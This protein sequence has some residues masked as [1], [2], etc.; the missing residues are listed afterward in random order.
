ML[1]DGLAAIPVMNFLTKLAIKLVDSPRVLQKVDDLMHGI[2]VDILVCMRSVL[3]RADSRR[4][5]AAAGMAWDQLNQEKFELTLASIHKHRL[6]RSG[7]HED[8][9]MVNILYLMTK[10]D[11]LYSL[12]YFP[13]YLMQVAYGE[14][15]ELTREQDIAAVCCAIIST[16][17]NRGKN[18]AAPRLQISNVV[19]DCGAFVEMCARVEDPLMRLWHFRIITQWSQKPRVLDE[20]SKNERAL[21]YV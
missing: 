10:Q 7:V 6:K 21:R 5:S 9:D 13:D 19:T 16:Q 3:Q 17:A 8:K 1:E 12:V 4:S 18:S 20:I 2:F 14:R 15:Q 11:F